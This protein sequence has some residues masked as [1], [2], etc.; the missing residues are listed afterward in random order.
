VT[1]K[2]DKERGGGKE[3]NPTKL[4]E[5]TPL[6]FPGSDYS[7][8]LQAV[9]EMKGTLHELKKAIEIL[10][11]QSKENHDKLSK[12]SHLIYAV[13]AVVTVI[14]FIAGYVIKALW[15]LISPIIRSHLQ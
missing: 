15:D 5:T 9:F 12:M 2:E 11:Q 6:S 1:P 10:T 14:G 7:F 13:S 3:V 8:T 4:P